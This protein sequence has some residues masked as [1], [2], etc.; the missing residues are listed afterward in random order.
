MRVIDKL[1][2][3][4]DEWLNIALQQTKNDN[5]KASEILQHFYLLIA[6]KENRG[7]EIMIRNEESY[8]K[9]S[10]KN[11]AHKAAKKNQLDF[12]EKEIIDMEDDTQQEEKI[13]FEEFYSHIEDY[14]S[15]GY[16]MDTEMFRIGVLRLYY[17]EGMTMK[18]ISDYTGITHR[19]IQLSI[20]SVRALM[21]DKFQLK[22]NNYKKTINKLR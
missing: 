5:D 11:L 19:V 4:N 20:E 12:T 7:E 3:R 21:K 10:L 1:A 22:Y 14:L 8:V 9:T 15:Q 17:Y 18:E 13:L 6:E 16:K 2:M